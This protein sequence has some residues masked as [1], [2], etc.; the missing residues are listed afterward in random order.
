M[1][2]I[3]PIPLGSE[4]MALWSELNR[5]DLAGN[6]WLQVRL[7]AGDPAEC[8][9]RLAEAEA[10]L[11]A[12]RKAI[13]HQATAMRRGGAGPLELGILWHQYRAAQQRAR[14]WRNALKK[15]EET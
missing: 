7:A 12:W 2:I 4:P 8:R 3:A 9:R 14:L 15:T 10:E 6:L 13:R 11:P 5:Q 1:C